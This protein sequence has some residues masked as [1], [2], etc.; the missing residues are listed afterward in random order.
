MKRVILILLIILCILLAI[1]LGWYLFFRGS[2]G[3][4]ADVIRNV[5]P[6]GT[7][8]D[9]NIPAGQPAPN[10]ATVPP[11]V[12]ENGRPVANLF[13]I[14]DT[15]VAG[16]V[17]ITKNK[18]TFVRYV[19]RATGHIFDVN[20]NT[21]EKIRV[22][23]NTLPK[24]YEAY[25]RPDGAAVLLRSLGNDGD[26]VSNLTL[27]IGST[28]AAT[29][30]R[31]NIGDVS[32]GAGNTLYYA[33]TDSPAI[34]SSTF[35]GSAL[36]TLYTSPF[37]SWRGLPYGSNLLLYTKA[38]S[39]I[40]GFAYSLNTSGALTRLLG[41]LDGLTVIANPSGTRLLYSYNEADGAKLFTKD[42]AVSTPTEILPVTLAEKCVWSIKER[43]ALFCATPLGGI[44]TGEPDN[45]YR[46][47]THFSDSIWRFNTATDIAQ[48]LVEPKKT[49]GVDLDITR[50][51]L[52]PNEDYLVFINKNDLSLWALKLF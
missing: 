11:V 8:E 5:L 50:P 47:I 32:V 51:I 27:T 26:T 13:R 10:A 40:P 39:R 34:V 49:Y 31:G 25:F 4:V 23:N 22:T 43:D 24:I 15:P 46:G 21:M 1:M 16:A 37:K 3:P 19:D 20:P 42:T 30:L 45:W 35:T 7:G 52:T 36:K 6:F 28:T 38:S 12:D 33:L 14:T 41:P 44:G 29:V 9:V 2:Q 48:V 17:A 18:Q